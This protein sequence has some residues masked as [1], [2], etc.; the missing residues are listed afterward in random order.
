M[1]EHFATKK[2][3]INQFH[4]TTYFA[5]SSGENLWTDW[6]L[7]ANNGK[8]SLTGLFKSSSKT[9]P[10][11]G[12]PAGLSPKGKYSTHIETAH[13]NQCDGKLATARNMCKLLL[14]VFGIIEKMK[15]RVDL[16]C[17]TAQKI[18]T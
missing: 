15:L 3:T 14:L 16:E 6:N 11:Y 18:T 7:F 12:G 10:T 4:T 9:A 8:N 1:E 5:N 17:N 2:F 13:R